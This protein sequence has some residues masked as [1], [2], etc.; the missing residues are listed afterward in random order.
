MDL[1]IIRHGVA[2]EREEWSGNDDLRPLTD[3]GI[4]KMRKAA[5]GLRTLIEA[6]DVMASSPLVRAQQTAQL[7]TKALHYSR[8]IETV[9]ALRP[10]QD[11]QRF[12]DWLVSYAD[13]D[14]IAIAGHE[15]HLS[16][17]AWWLLTAKRE[18]RF[19]L[20]KGGACLLRF[21]DAI[22]AGKAQLVWLLT[23]TQLRALAR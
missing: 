12:L 2:V 9:D 11:P 8:D 6:V 16:T 4:S 1:L 21:D 22:D 10:G 13:S 19:E 15:P 7:V 18:A 20:K 17:L 5:Q 14:V 23:P 3:D